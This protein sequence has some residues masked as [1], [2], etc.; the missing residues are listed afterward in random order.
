[1]NEEFIKHTLC[2]VERI[3]K[4]CVRKNAGKRVEGTGLGVRGWRAHHSLHNALA[5][6]PTKHLCLSEVSDRLELQ[7]GHQGS[8][9]RVWGG[10]VRLGAQ[11][12]T[13]APL[14]PAWDSTEARYWSPARLLPTQPS[15]TLEFPSRLSQPVSV[16]EPQTL[17]SSIN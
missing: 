6:A 3:L 13:T 9:T 11:P 1:M 14:T 15:P 7:G 10:S 17:S 12:P 4:R 2:F 16:R 5:H 8:H